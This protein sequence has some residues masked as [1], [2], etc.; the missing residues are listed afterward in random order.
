[1]QTKKLTIA[2]RLLE[3]FKDGK[4]H[5]VA[6]IQELFFDEYTERGNIYQHISRTRKLLKEKEMLLC[7]IHN[8]SVHYQLVIVYT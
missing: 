7:V 5:S 4:P 8:R 3:F 6:E 1:M 2:D